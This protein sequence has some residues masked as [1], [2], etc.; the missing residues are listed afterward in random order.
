M[1][2]NRVEEDDPLET[3]LFAVAQEVD[4][5]VI[6]IIRA[7]GLNPATAR[8]FRITRDELTAEIEGVAIR[9]LAKARDQGERDVHERTTSEHQ[10]PRN[11]RKTPSGT[12]ETIDS[13]DPRT[14]KATPTL[15]GFPTQDLRR[16]M[17]RSHYP[18]EED[19]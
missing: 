5:H 16:G 12:F 15:M 8:R 19:G 11:P 18:P 7:M 9:V 14:R 4:T 17:K 13:N 1:V 2:D 6:R 10:I 3:L